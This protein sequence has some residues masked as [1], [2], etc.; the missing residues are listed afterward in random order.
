MANNVK[1]GDLAILVSDEE[2][3]NIGAIVQVVE[4][5][6]PWPT[7]ELFWSCVTQGRPLLCANVNPITGEPDGTYE[8]SH[9]FEIR[10]SDL[11]PISG[12]PLE[13]EVSAPKEISLA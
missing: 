7:D 11:R 12:L 8:R 3:E 13:D 1:P 6:R 2:P 4:R 10:D 9:E 5:S